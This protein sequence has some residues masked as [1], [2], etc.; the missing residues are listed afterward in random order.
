M[1][2]QKIKERVIRTTLKTEG[3][4]VH[5]PLVASVVLLYLQTCWYVMI[6]ERTVCCCELKGS[7]R[8]LLICLFFQLK[9]KIPL[10]WISIWSSCQYCLFYFCVVLLFYF[11]CLFVCFVLLCFC[12]FVFVC[13]FAFC[14]W[15][16]LCLVLICFGVFYRTNNP[17]KLIINIL[18]FLNQTI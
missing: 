4:A 11:V 3:K 15:L 13:F 17:L 10:K 18:R 16:F 5:A 12:I 7:R 2:T 8:Y 14:V 6:E 1:T 9:Q